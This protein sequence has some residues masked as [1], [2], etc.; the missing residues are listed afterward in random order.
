MALQEP[1]MRE[2][3]VQK[4]EVCVD[5]ISHPGDGRIRVKL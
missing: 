1:S 4:G 5:G 2:M 3:R